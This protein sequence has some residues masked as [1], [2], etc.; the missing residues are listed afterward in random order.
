MIALVV[1]QHD[2]EAWGI[3][4]CVVALWGGGCWLG[5]RSLGKAIREAQLDELWDDAGGQDEVAA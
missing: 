2:L 4:V 5:W 3:L 1:A